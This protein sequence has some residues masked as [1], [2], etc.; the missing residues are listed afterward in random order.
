MKEE[1]MEVFQEI[2]VSDMQIKRNLLAQIFDKIKDYSEFKETCYKR[3]RVLTTDPNLQNP[4]DPDKP[5]LHID[6]INLIHEIEDEYL[7]EIY[8]LMKKIKEIN[9]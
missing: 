9:P 6:F 3:K 8:K 2:Q 5:G 4:K 7:D 1:N